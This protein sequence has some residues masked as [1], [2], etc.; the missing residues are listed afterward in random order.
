ML[1]CYQP[2]ALEE[3]LRHHDDFLDTCLKECVLTSPALATQFA[4]MMEVCTTF[5]N[6]SDWYTRCRLKVVSS[7]SASQAIGDMPGSLTLASHPS[8]LESA[9]FLQGGT[10]PTPQGAAPHLQ[11][12]EGEFMGH[13]KELL[14]A[15]RFFGS[16]EAACIGNLLA[17]MDYNLYYSAI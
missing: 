11:R 10:L 16:T 6:F 15:L 8:T 1:K 17:R 9:F 4:R 2:L 13:M 14:D 12:L 7:W 3:V 5:A